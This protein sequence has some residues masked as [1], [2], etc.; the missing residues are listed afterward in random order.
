MNDEFVTPYS[1]ER[2]KA[3]WPPFHDI[4]I[5]M[6]A[7]D[8]LMLVGTARDSTDLTVLFRH[9]AIEWDRLLEEPSDW[10]FTDLV[11]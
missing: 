11:P 4:G 7:G 1:S 6:S 9:L 2:R 5:Y 10:F 3:E 8:S